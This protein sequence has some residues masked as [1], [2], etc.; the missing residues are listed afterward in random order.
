MPTGIGI[1][2]SFNENSTATLLAS[3]ILDSL[4]AGIL[5]YVALVHLV[6]PLMTDSAWLHGRGWPM[7]VL[8]FICFYSGA[9]AM[10]FIGK[11]A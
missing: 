4:S 10:A 5:I 11:Y 8:A 6:E 7:Q 3:G 2:E 9:G 1:R